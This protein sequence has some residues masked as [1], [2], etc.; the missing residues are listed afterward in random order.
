MSKLFPLVLSSLLALG[1]GTPSDNGN[2]FGTGTRDDDDAA[3]DDDDAFVDID[4][5]AYL[6]FNRSSEFEQGEAL[7]VMFS[8]WFNVSDFEPRIPLPPKIDTCHSDSNPA[9]TFGTPPTQ[10][11]IG[12]PSVTT[13][14]GSVI[15]LEL[16][17]D[18]WFGATSTNDWESHQDYDIAISG[19]ADRDAAQY[20][21]ALATPSVLTL[22]NLEENEDG[23][24]L[25]WY[26]E[27][28]NGHVEVR[29]IHTSDLPDQIQTWVVCRF[30]DD[31]EHTVT[32]QDFELLS[33]MPVELEVLRSVTANFET[34]QGAPGVASGTSTAFTTL[35]MP[36]VPE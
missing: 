24:Y 6:E 29:L 28:N 5:S 22:L 31:G 33:G 14:D 27:N 4:R 36:V 16:D 9:G 2:G 10:H 23:L 15:E 18:Y 26:G 34:D 8:S 3:D 11:D 35:T 7:T 30:F 12:V 1:C 25:E 19:G 20:P 17:G 32:W 13:P 21:G